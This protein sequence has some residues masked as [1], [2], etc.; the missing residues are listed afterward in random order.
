MKHN[1]AGQTIDI[2]KPKLRSHAG[3]G[4]SHGSPLTILKQVWLLG[5]A[6]G[7]GSDDWLIWN[8]GSNPSSGILFIPVAN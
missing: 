2:G 4:K 8:G 1:R 3:L 7:S 5:S 6:S